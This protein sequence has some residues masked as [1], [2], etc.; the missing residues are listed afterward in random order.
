[1]ITNWLIKD[2]IL[3]FNKGELNELIISLGEDGLKYLAEDIVEEYG[4]KIR[5]DSTTK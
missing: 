1:M 3:I 5:W 2:G 4:G